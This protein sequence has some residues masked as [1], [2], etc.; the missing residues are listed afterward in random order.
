MI[1]LII[2]YCLSSDTKTCVEK[3]V[4]MEDF[5]SPAGCTMAGQQRAQAYLAEHP[6]YSLKSF[7]CEV[8]MPKQ[9]PT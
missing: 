1:E 9:A 5:A 7:R 2:V 4:P 3:R 6:K 8:D